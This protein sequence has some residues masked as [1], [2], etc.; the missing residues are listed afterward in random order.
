MAAEVLDR[1][2]QGG[3]INGE[4]AQEGAEFHH[5]E[6]FP[7]GVPQLGGFCDDL[8]LLLGG[9]GTRQGWGRALSQRLVLEWQ[10]A[11][12]RGIETRE[13]FVLQGIRE[14]QWL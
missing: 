11:A 9:Q 4:I 10:G 5:R 13:A 8:G 1:C 12:Q 3:A 14:P 6:G 7:G 2:R